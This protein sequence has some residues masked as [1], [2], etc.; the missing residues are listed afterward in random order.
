[1]KTATLNKGFAAFL[2]LVL[3]GVASA[4]AFTSPAPSSHAA[5]GH[6][7]PGAAMDGGYVS[8]EPANAP[9]VVEARL[10]T[11][12]EIAAGEPVAMDAAASVSVEAAAA[13]AKA[14]L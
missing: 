11:D 14:S 7:L 3:V 10:L 4:I 5:A 8:V 9:P 2:G 6:P 13:P 1:M 12:G